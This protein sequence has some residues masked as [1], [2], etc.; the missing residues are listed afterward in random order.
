MMA[1]ARLLTLKRS[2]ATK[3]IIKKKNSQKSASNNKLSAKLSLPFPA[4]IQLNLDC[5]GNVA[6][7]SS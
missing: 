6:F 5:K 2:G 4:S 1:R 3:I 7:L